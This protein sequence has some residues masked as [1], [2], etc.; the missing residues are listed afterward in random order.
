MI[1]ITKLI[2]LKTTIQAISAMG[3]LADLIDNKLKRI[4]LLVML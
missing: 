1:T 4:H 3:T 2:Y